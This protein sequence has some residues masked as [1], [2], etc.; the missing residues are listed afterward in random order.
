MKAFPG[1][2]ISATRCLFQA[3]VKDNGIS[4]RFNWVSLTSSFCLPFLFFLS[5]TP[6]FLG[7]QT[8]LITVVS[9]TSPRITLLVL[10]KS[11]RTQNN[12][13]SF[14][15]CIEIYSNSFSLYRPKN[16]VLPQVCWS[17]PN[18]GVLY[19]VHHNKCGCKAER[20]GTITLRRKMML[21]SFTPGI[22]SNWLQICFVLGRF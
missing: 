19:C 1:Q 16:Y 10:C 7:H 18:P 9:H 2:R 4:C 11:N 3:G 14:C 6:F 17:F 20:E 22:V 5:S 21:G 8:S 15:A 13:Y 12:Y